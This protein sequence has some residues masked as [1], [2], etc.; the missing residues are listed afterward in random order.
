MKKKTT[1]LSLNKVIVSKL[2]HFKGGDTILEDNTVAFCH[3]WGDLGYDCNAP[4]FNPR[5]CGLTNTDSEPK[6]RPSCTMPC[7]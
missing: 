4:S 2:N 5:T 3:S 6:K 7:Y 1:T